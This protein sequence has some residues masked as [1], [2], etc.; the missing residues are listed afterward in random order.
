MSEISVQ[1]V[2]LMALSTLLEQR[3]SNSESHIIRMQHYVQELAF[4][5]RTHPT[6]VDVLTPQYLEYL[7]RLTPLYDLGTAGIPDRVLIKPARLDPEEYALMCTHTLIGCSA[8]ERAQKTL[9]IDNADEAMVMAK[10]IILSHHEKW[11]GS[12]YPHRLVGDAIPISA[13]L[14][15]LADVYDA[16]ISSKVYKQG[17]SHNEAVKII[18]SERSA[19]FDPVIVDMFM[20]MH[21]SFATIAQRYADTPADMQ[22]KIDY[23]A[24]AIA[25]NADNL[26]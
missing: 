23:M 8:I 17:L 2:L 3:D 11:D 18:F 25:E 13:R 19:H 20:D 21:E 7:V 6:F 1:W 22:H 12:G 14:V 16:L 26:P 10:E 15:A 4:A 5:L 9:G 24:K